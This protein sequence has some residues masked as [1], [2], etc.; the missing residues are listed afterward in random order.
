MR[1]LLQGAA[2]PLAAR[3]DGRAVNQI[4]GFIPPLN[5]DLRRIGAHLVRDLVQVAADHHM[6]IYRERKRQIGAQAVRQRLTGHH[7]A[8]GKIAGQTLQPRG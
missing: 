6:S 4:T 1:N 7:N 3:I 5:R 8:E 2:S